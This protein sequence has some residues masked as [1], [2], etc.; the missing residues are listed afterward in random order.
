MTLYVNMSIMIH[1]FIVG[2]IIS[3]RICISEYLT[4]RFILCTGQKVNMPFKNFLHRHLNS[5]ITWQKQI[6]QTLRGLSVVLRLSL[7]LTKTTY[8][9]NTLL[10]IIQLKVLSFVAFQYISKSICRVQKQSQELFSHE[11]IYKYV[12]NH[13]TLSERTLV[14][15]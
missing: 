2:I 5:E 14:H 12:K 13:K 10:S 9:Y 1:K 3:N 4:Y 15:F 7:F 8:N 11:A 6:L